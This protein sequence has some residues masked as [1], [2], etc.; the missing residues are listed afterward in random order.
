[1]AAGQQILREMV[2][3]M[4]KFNQIKMTIYVPVPTFLLSKILI[5]YFSF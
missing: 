3:S 2:S 1:M 4:N 5:D